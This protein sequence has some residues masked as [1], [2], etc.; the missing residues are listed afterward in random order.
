MPQAHFLISSFKKQQHFTLKPIMHQIIYF[1]Q[2]EGVCKKTRKTAEFLE[3]SSK[4]P[5][6]YPYTNIL[7]ESSCE[8]R[9]IFSTS[10][11]SHPPYQLPL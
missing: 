4:Q 5:G 11:M 10:I 8:T 9:S 3:K 2:A 1:S 6:F 7:T